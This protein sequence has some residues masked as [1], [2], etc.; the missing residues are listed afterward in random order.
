MCRYMRS[1]NIRFFSY[2]YDKRNRYQ[3]CL[4]IGD[5]QA[6]FGLEE[7]REGLKAVPKLQ[8][9]AEAV[10]ERLGGLGLRHAAVLREDAGILIK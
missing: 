10:I 3:G 6:I 4:Q 5:A 7:L 9:H 1:T 8:K 2:S